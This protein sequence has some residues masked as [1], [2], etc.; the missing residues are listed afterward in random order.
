[1][2][3][4]NCRLQS[5]IA[6]NERLIKI[7]DSCESYSSLENNSID[8]QIKCLN[9]LNQCNK[10]KTREIEQALE[11]KVNSFHETLTNFGDNCICDGYIWHSPV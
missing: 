1:M 7:Y 11:Q 9:R 3:W 5:H 6:F 10:K 2:Q 4:S 8:N